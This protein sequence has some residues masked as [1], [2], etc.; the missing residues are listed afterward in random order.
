[1]TTKSLNKIWII[2]ELWCPDT[3]RVIKLLEFFKVDYEWV[4]S[5]KEKEARELIIRVAGK[6]KIPLVFFPDGSYLVEP[7]DE[8]MIE[9]LNLDIRKLSEFYIRKRC[10]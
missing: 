2:G 9:K 5:S 3:V 1:M 6:Y 4:D 7:S 8:Q 10:I